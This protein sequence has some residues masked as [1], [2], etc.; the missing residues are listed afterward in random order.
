MELPES[1]DLPD[2]CGNRLAYFPGLPREGDGGLEVERGMLPDAAM[3]RVNG[4]GHG[5]F[6]PLA[7][8]QGKAGKELIQW[9]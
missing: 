3:E 8:C 2:F 5:V 6:G 7:D 9:S 1:L 4:A